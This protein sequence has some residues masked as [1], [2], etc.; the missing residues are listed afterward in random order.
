MVNLKAEI[1]EF[2]EKQRRITNTSV[3]SSTD[4]DY[5]EIDGFSF[6]RI[7]CGYTFMEGKTSYPTTY[8][9]L[10]R[11][12]ERK[13]WKVYGWKNYADMEEKSE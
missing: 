5:Y 7:M 8:V 1:Q 2:R 13:H 6:A 11:K 10:L 4:V 9:Y 3:A 12:D